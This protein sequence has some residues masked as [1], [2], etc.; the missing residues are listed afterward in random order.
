MKTTEIYDILLRTIQ[1]LVNK[2]FNPVFESYSP[3]ETQLYL[4][5]EIGCYIDFASRNKMPVGVILGERALETLYSEEFIRKDVNRQFNDEPEGDMFLSAAEDRLDDELA[6]YARRCRNE[7]MDCGLSDD[8]R[9][10]LCR[11]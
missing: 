6:D 11:I 7:F 4:P 8:N 10:S 2:E 3:A 9:L 5:E 1:N